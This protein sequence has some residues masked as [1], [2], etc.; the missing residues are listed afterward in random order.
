MAARVAAGSL[1]RALATW[2]DWDKA[3]RGVRFLD[4]DYEPTQHLLTRFEKAAHHGA[5]VL[6]ATWLAE[7]ASLAPPTPGSATIEDV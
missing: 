7:L 3:H 2:C 6:T 1:L 4:D 5:D